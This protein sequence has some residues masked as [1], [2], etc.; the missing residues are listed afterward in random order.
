MDHLAGGV[1]VSVCG[2][3][4]PAKALALRVREGWCGT[5]GQH[6]E[7]LLRRG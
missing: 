7:G 5:Q 4:Q 3:R 1:S 2:G 6:P